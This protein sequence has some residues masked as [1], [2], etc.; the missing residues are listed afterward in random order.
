MPSANGRNGRNV[1]AWVALALIVAGIVFTAGVTFGAI[2][3]HG[4]RIEKLE[5]QR[6]AFT[7]IMAE[8]K[9]EVAKIRTI[10]EERAKREAQPKRKETER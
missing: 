9:L 10:L 8:V 3:E 4:Q 7:T 2:A 6:E 1:R 5:T